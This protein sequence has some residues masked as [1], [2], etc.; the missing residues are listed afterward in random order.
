[1]FKT[2]FWNK[3]VVKIVSIFLI[4][5]F[6]QI[7]ISLPASSKTLEEIEQEIDSKE[8]ELQSLEDKLKEAQ[9]L[10]EYYNSQKGATTSQLENIQ[11]EL[12][13]VEAELEVNQ[14]KVKKVKKQLDLVKLELEEKEISM[15]ER[16]LDIYI[17]D[18]QGIVDFIIS[19]VKAE[20]FWK[21]YKYRETLLD[22]DLEDID[23]LASDV[24]DIKK[25]KQQF[26]LDLVALEEES[27]SL[28]SMKQDLENQIA[29]YSSLAAHNTNIQS[30]IRAQ[31]GS[32]Q[33]QIEGLTEEHQQ[34]LA[35]E[36]NIL[37]GANGGTK[38][39]ESGEYYFHGQ[40]RYIYQGHGLGF[41]QYGAMGGAQK[42][43]SADNIA[44]FY[45][46]GSVIGSASGT[47]SVKDYGVMDIEDY[48]AGLG[49]VPDKACGTQSQVDDR[50][51]KYAIDSASTIWDCWPEESIKAQVIVARSYGMAYSGTICTTASCQ[52]YKGG[53]GK[54]WAADETKGKVVKAGGN[55]IKAFY[56]SDNNNGWGTGT[57]KNPMWCSTF[58]GNCGA[59]YSWLQSVNDS[60][61]AAKGP[62]TD[63]LWRTNSY[64]L[65]ELESMLKWYGDQNYSYPSSS[66]V[67]GV[68]ASIG[69]L[70]DFKFERDASGRVARII[71]VGENGERKING[72][73][74]KTIFI[75][76]VYNIQPSGEVDPIFSLTYYF[77]KV[78]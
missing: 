57:H 6:F 74:F 44:K 9:E 7:S 47:I 1:M 11:N 4:L 14:A 33:Q 31:M 67:R 27:N 52:V 22:N 23:V 16:L 32:V 77:R 45:Y 64:S 76:W 50:P 28:A 54:K 38:P 70:T 20:G 30:G 3:R 65:E 73:F 55:I 10:V 46:K 56:S 60:S 2:S 5:I 35:E 36:M 39:L 75:F 62:Y 8:S 58:D 17:Y 48:V 53:D 66:D 59:G 61:F 40:G 26:E 69:K 15:N 68:L 51:D 71:A 29:S 18:R 41:S 78:P 42:G 63:W 43:M 19:N 13:K 21:E 34:M 72:D 24:A 37:K 25:Q 49:E 12:K